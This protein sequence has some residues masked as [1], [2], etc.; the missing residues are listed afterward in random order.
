MS[1]ANRTSKATVRRLELQAKALELRRAGDG[2][3][4][5][6]QKLGIGKSTAHRMVESAMAGARA[7][8]AASVDDLR[9]DE[10][11]RLD[12]ML[13]KLWPKVTD[14]PDVAVIDRIIKIGERRAK[15]LGL[16]APVRTALQGGGDDAPPISTVSEAKV[17]FYMPDNGRG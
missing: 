10:L 16:D 4:E 15:L 7:Q 3:V 11:T 13:A 9:A 5:I 8:I 6:A 14:D 2:Y 12:G 1:R 17:T